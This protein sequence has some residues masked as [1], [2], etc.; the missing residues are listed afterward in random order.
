MECS[1][2][3]SFC[4]NFPALF[5]AKVKGEEGTKRER[6]RDKTNK[7][8]S[9]NELEIGQSRNL[10]GDLFKLYSILYIHLTGRFLS[11]QI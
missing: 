11:C 2:A 9:K 6:E 3:R 5:T 8:W 4:F 1:D 10:G 7:N